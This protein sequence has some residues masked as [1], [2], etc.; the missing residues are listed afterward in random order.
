MPVS[1]EEAFATLETLAVPQTVETLHSAEKMAR[2]VGMVV[3]ADE[4]YEISMW[5]L[6]KVNEVAVQMA[7]MA[8]ALIIAKLLGSHTAKRPLSG[9]LES[10]ILSQPGPV[11]MVR[12][13][14]ISELDKAVNPE[15]GY[16]P[17]WRAQEYG[18]GVS[19]GGYDGAIET[20]VGRVLGQGTFMMS[21]T[22]PD[23]EK[24]GLNVGSDEMFT[25]GGSNPGWGTINVD[26]PGRHFLRDGSAEAGLRYVEVMTAVRTDLDLRLTAVLDQARKRTPRGGSFLGIIQA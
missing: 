6:R 16:G 22:P 2:S 7:G 1:A 13:G 20:Q 4:L 23:S 8:D 14:I 24:R 26:L 10:H 15:P 17:F 5:L 21:G 18:T 12:V 3:M 9:N 19:E 11:G 25:P